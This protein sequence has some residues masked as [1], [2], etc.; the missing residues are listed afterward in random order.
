MYYVFHGREKDSMIY[1]KIILAR[2][3]LAL[4]E[5]SNGLKREQALWENMLDTDLG[6]NILGSGSPPY[7]KFNC[8]TCLN[9]LRR[10][11]SLLCG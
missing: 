10:N 3:Q 2:G 4:F 9:F 7:L 8:H 1:F 5:I 6:K 11:I